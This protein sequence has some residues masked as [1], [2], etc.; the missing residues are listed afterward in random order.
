[1]KPVLAHPWPASPAE[2]IALQNEL[3]GAI[4]IQPLARTVRLIAGA[5]VGFSQVTERLYAA[6][7]VL[8]AATLA[9]VEKAEAEAVATFPYVPGLLTF[10]EVPTLL[11]AFEKLRVEPDAVLFDGQGLAHPRRFGLACHGGLLLGVPSVGCA[12]T[13]LVGRHAP[14]ALERGARADLIHRGEIVGAAVRTRA[15]VMPVYV[16]AGHLIDL[17]SA[18]DLVLKATTR[19]RLPEPTRLAHHATTEFRLRREGHAGQDEREC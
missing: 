8:D 9:P 6:V 3:R 1:M 5:D 15:N 18:I 11:R 12:K 10:R 16:S 4:R 17:P 7:V 13:I 19:F 2:A 14:L